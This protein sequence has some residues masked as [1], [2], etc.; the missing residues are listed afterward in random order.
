MPVESMDVAYTYV[1]RLGPEAEVLDPP[2][3]RALLADAA[4]RMRR[5]YR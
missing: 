2:E 4:D 5:L 3:L 1:L